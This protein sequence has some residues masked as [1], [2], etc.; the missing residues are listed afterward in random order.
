MYYILDAILILVITF[1]II[2]SMKKGFVSVSK[3]F[4]SLILTWILMS[5]V[6]PMLLDALKS[7]MFG[8]KIREKVSEN[9]SSVYEKEDFAKETNTA[10]I[11]AAEK[12]CEAL[13]F[14]AFVEN[15]IKSTVSGMEKVEKNVMDVITDAVTQMVL[16]ILS[17]LLMFLLVRLAVFLIVKMLEAAF[18][19][20]G[21]KKINK[22]LGAILGIVNALLI[23]Y[24]SCAAVSLFT[25]ADSRILI[26]AA[27][28]KTLILKYFYENNVLMLLFV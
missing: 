23:V 26:D 19:M 20:P 1:C 5:S 9:I 25:P 17:M 11:D 10:D 8:E 13:G 22:T 16:N 18:E 14:P 24:I 21:L 7:S 28:M 27:V 15:S 2:F 6:Q 4:I 3:S 12:I